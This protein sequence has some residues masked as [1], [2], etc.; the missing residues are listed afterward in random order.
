MAE[1]PD[2]GASRRR[3][4]SREGD[5]NK[6]WEVCVDANELT[7]HWGRIGSTGQSKTKV[8]ASADK[9]A[10]EQ[11]KLISQKLRKG[12]QE[13]RSEGEREPADSHDV[14][15]TRSVN[16]AVD[17]RHDEPPAREPEFGDDPAVDML[18]DGVA[19]LDA[20]LI[21]KAAAMGARLDV[22]P[23]WRVTPLWAVLHECP[24]PGAK[25][26][27]ATLVELG[28]SIDE[29]LGE[30]AAIKCAP[31]YGTEERSIERLR[32]ALSF[33]ADI[34]AV[35]PSSGNTALFTNIAYRRKDV[36][37]YLIENGADPTIRNNKGESAI[38]RLQQKINE[39]KASQALEY[40]ELLSLITS[41]PT[42]KEDIVLPQL[43]DCVGA[44]L[45][46]VTP[47][48][49]F[50][51]DLHG[52]SNDLRQFVVR[53]E[54][55]LGVAIQPEFERL[56]D[57][58][59]LQASGELTDESLTRI[60]SEF[61]AWPRPEGPIPFADLYTVS[62]IAAI[63]EQAVAAKSSNSAVESP[64]QAI[65][66][67]ISDDWGREQ[68]EELGDRQFRLLLAGGCRH[69]FRS[70]LRA[71]VKDALETLEAYADTGKTRTAL[72]KVRQTFRSLW[73][74]ARRD[75]RNQPEFLAIEKSLS[76]DNLADAV[77][78]LIQGIAKRHELPERIAAD[79]FIRLQHD[80]DSPLES[81]DSFE[82][83]WRTPEVVRIANAMYESRDFR[84]MFQLADALQQAG[85][86]NGLVL[87]HCRNPIA[88]HV[89]GCWV[90]DAILD[91]SWAVPS[92]PEKIRSKSLLSRFP[93]PVQYEIT[94]IMDDGN[95]EMS[96]EDLIAEHWDVA[97]SRPELAARWRPNLVE[98]HPE[99]SGEQIDTLLSFQH[100]NADLK[101][102][103]IAR[104][105]ALEDPAELARGLAVCNRLHLMF[106]ARD[107]GACDFKGLFDLC[108]TRETLL[109]ERSVDGV[110]AGND[111]F[112]DNW[113]RIDIA[114]TAIL[115]KDAETLNL[116]T[117]RLP[118][119]MK[120]AKWIEGIC[121]CLIGVAER[122]PEQVA[123]G[124]AQH[125]TSIQKMRQKDEL[126]GAINLNAQGLYRLC[127]WASPE[128][129]SG[130]DA[131]Q[132]VPWDAEFHEWC[133]EHPD[134]LAGTDLKSVSTVLHD[135]VLLGKPPAWL[136][137]PGESRFEVVLTGGDPDW[138]KKYF[139]QAEFLQHCPVALRW[140]L[141]RQLA[142]GERCRIEEGGGLA[143]VR[144]MVSGPCQY[145]STRRGRPEAW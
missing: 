104:R 51:G 101:K 142:E 136:E 20:A 44:D 66:R 48:K 92:K 132:G 34:N 96:L 108:A 107:Q 42:Q 24:R 21:R 27:V 102:T 72:R 19:D 60:A 81:A 6:F 98:R 95:G 39:S 74:D 45:Q 32:V 13:V 124:L 63:V 119:I 37:R 121:T 133:E 87:D 93:K 31:H 109:A 40:Q 80:M 129:V 71:S 5:S 11:D 84:Q 85:C 94:R 53:L 103:A 140:N 117:S 14:E 88:I 114:V 130:F 75:W 78:N 46:S 110:R 137:S 30:P 106:F 28:A 62:L 73:I 120:V 3:F 68:Y 70:D 122:Q 69:S 99:L 113:E 76:V 35:D 105:F 23:G 141:T 55:H 79:E 25:E 134:P 54:N 36:T 100:L 65:T 127:E 7:T 8:L 22:L 139:K 115:Q 58:T 145:F 83:G 77:P 112:P 61:T 52:S 47:E 56:T 82:S 1:N 86:D 43:A 16:V 111:A 144:P 116:V 125:L 138:A 41:E 26:C 97:R 12:Y 143:E 118:E 123:S 38:D 49:R 15:S 131:T 33:G 57:L 89:R 128:L 90:V 126:D 17:D 2:G 18:A 4:E 135:A 59:E 64:R 9:A 91:G 29:D 50:F 67:H 10:A